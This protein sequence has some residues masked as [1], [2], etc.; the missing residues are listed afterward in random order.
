MSHSTT[1]TARYVLL[2][3]SRSYPQTQQETN[4]EWQHYTKP[5]IK[6][7]LSKSSNGGE[8]ESAFLRIV[9]CIEDSHPQ[10]HNELVFENFDMLTFSS[11]PS[12]QD[13]QQSG[14]PLKAVY[15]DSVVGIRYL[16]T[17]NGLF[18][19][20]QITFQSTSHAFEFVKALSS[21]CPCKANTNAAA[22][23]HIM[24]APSIAPS[25]L[26]V[27]SVLP[28]SHMQR[29]DLLPAHGAEVFPLSHRNSSHPTAQFSHSTAPYSGLLVPSASPRVD[30]H[31]LLSSS[32]SPPQLSD[33]F[34]ASQSRPY[35]PISSTQAPVH[36]E[37]YS[38]YSRP[39]PVDPPSSFPQSSVAMEPPRPVTSK[40]KREISEKEVQTV[41]Q[42]V[43]A[44]QEATPLY[45]MPRTS[46]EQLVGDVVREDGF[47]RLVS[48]SRC[49]L[50]V[51]T[52]VL[53][54]KVYLHCGR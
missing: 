45:H 40:S 20:F 7:T 46:L 54:W 24:A 3:Y 5:V 34:S 35:S 43:F 37:Q 39:S 13:K 15:R 14:L 23:N 22:Q 53:R 49:Q 1:T 9:W 44:L 12:R 30:Q 25:R 29:T 47:V 36:S 16:N 33:Q 48:E 19:R 4:S 28:P 18:R 2:K 50:I 32:P 42:F 27:P 6:L 17:D 8:L 26:P 41:E 21:V 38:Q 51:L 52:G 10:H 11:L 31:A